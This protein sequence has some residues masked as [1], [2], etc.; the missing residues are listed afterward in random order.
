MDL[1]RLGRV[2]LPTALL[3]LILVIHAFLL[4]DNY[5]Y[6]YASSSLAYR[7][8]FGLSLV[9]GLYLLLFLVQGT[10]VRSSYPSGT[11]V[12]GMVL[13]LALAVT[14]AHSLAG[15]AI[16][17]G[18]GTG[19][20]EVRVAL[21]GMILYLVLAHY[22][23]CHPVD[24]IVRWFVRLALLSAAF[25]LIVFVSGAPIRLT[26]VNEYGRSTAFEG[27]FLLSWCLG[28]CY[29]LA[30]ALL[31]RRRLVNLCYSALFF[32]VISLSYRRFFVLIMLGGLAVIFLALPAKSVSAALKRRSILALAATILLVVVA[33]RRP[34]LVE[35]M[36]PRT[37]LDTE[38]EAYAR[39]YSSN[40]GHVSDV[41]LGWELLQQHPWLGIGLG[42]PFDG[43]GNA[44]IVGSLLHSQ[45]LHTWLRTGILGFVALLLFYCTLWWRARQ[46]LTG[47]GNG[48]G[49]PFA[50]MVL[51]VTVPHFFLTFIG[52]PFY[53]QQK[54]LFYFV[55][56][57]AV[58]ERLA[59]SGRS[60]P[61]PPGSTP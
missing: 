28:F 34:D 43:Q 45:H 52:P 40:A 27:G 14:M 23:E 57:F 29:C 7:V 6:W 42:V 44:P 24:P 16:F 47:S 32:A 12:L 15:G 48:I 56:L 59:Q 36:D 10:R 46:A 18:A 5:A 22:F 49:R 54:P 38:S 51:G 4:E 11:A 60:A 19:L 55:F 8:A 3:G 53:L 37:F 30:E 9:T 58:I 2:P 41:Q 13:S 31:N 25:H 61:L 35:R 20:L 39:S 26:G 33:W 17:Q 21:V 1:R 50:L